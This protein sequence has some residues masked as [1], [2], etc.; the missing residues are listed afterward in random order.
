MFF[1]IPHL[2]NFPLQWA[3]IITENHSNQNTELCKGVSIDIFIKQFLTLSSGN[4][5]KEETEDCKI[6]RSRSLLLILNCLLGLSEVATKPYHQHSCLN[7][8]W[9][10]TTKID[11]S[12]GYTFYTFHMM[13]TCDLLMRSL[14]TL[15]SWWIH[16]GR[17]VLLR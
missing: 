1:L 15:W 3:E 12:N 14:Q 11:M 8:N 16:S 10:R 5:V 17:A 6:R 13:H 4:R 2:Q 9:R 7:L